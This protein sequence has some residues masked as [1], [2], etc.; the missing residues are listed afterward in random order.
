M[1]TISN[2]TVLILGNKRRPQNDLAYKDPRISKRHL[3]IRSLDDGT[4]LHIQDLNTTNGT[5]V[6]GEFVRAARVT[7]QDKITVG[8][9]T[10]TGKKLLLACQKIWHKDKYDFYEEF[11]A[12]KKTFASYR[13]E[14]KSLQ[15]SHNYT[16]LVLRIVVVLIPLLI[17][18]FFG[19]QWGMHPGLRYTIPVI[20]GV[21]IAFVAEKIF[22]KDDLAHR[23]TRCKEKYAKQIV[24]PKCEESLIE[25]SY[26][27]W[28]AQRRC[29]NCEANWVR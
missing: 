14:K 27:Y 29:H 8:R 11:A 17:F 26:D 10:L 19:E 28:I 22:H 18:M 1:S 2:N 7:A 20:G 16:V 6:N 21:V 23:I 12:L 5:L 15:S 9:T 4:A 25:K 13:K 24:C 3:E